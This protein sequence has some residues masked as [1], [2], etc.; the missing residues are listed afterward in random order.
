MATL[1]RS[2]RT[3]P[4]ALTDDRTAL[5]A[6]VSWDEVRAIVQGALAIDADDLA[7]MLAELP[8]VA[9]ANADL[10]GLS[11]LYR[12][13]SLARA[14]GMSALEFGYLSSTLAKEVAQFGGEIGGMVPP[15]V[16]AALRERFAA[17]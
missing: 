1:C 7:L 16:A 3:T 13:V 9:G 6:A 17:G 2:G 15:P 8:E 12:H 4:L 10:A 14:T 5:R 11:A